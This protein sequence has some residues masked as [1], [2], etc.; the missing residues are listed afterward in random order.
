[1]AR[2]GGPCPVPAGGGRPVAGLE[3]G[4]GWPGGSPAEGAE[5]PEDATSHAE[6]WLDI[7]KSANSKLQILP[8]AYQHYFTS[9]P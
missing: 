7:S 8:H 5:W 3:E 1:M 6:T 9:F 4:A 2:A